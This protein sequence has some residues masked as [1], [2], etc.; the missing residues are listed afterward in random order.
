MQFVFS[1]LLFIYLYYFTFRGLRFSKRFFYFSDEPLEAKS[2]ST[3]TKD[4]KPAVVNPV[5]AWATQTGK[6]LLFFTKRSEDKATPAGIFN[7]VCY[8]FSFMFILLTNLLLPRPMSVMSSRRV[9]ANFT[10]RST[11]TS[12]PSRPVPPPNVKAG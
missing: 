9:L 7:L 11:A 6:G 3:F 2:L 12:I 4:A 5:A 1:I 8:S 10:S